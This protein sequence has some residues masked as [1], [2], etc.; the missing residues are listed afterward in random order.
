[1]GSPEV[2]TLFGVPAQS[3]GYFGRCEIIGSFHVMQQTMFDYL[4]NQGRKV[5]VSPKAV[6]KA[7]VQEGS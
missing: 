4:S 1:M 6:R 7:G 3:Q 2:G 5:I